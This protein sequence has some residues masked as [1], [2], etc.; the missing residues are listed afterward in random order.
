MDDKNSLLA[1]SAWAN[2]RQIWIELI[3]GR[4]FY[5]SAQRFPRLASA[6][7]A[8]LAQVQIRL[9]GA[10][11]RWEEIDEDL[12]IRGLVAE[13]SQSQTQRTPAHAN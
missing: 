4:Q 11:L 6:T 9:Q 10:A 8:Q 5:F 1:A 3:D 7:D 2:Q 13:Q 12:T